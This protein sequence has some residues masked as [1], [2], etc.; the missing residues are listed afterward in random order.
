[1]ISAGKNYPIVC[2][3]FLAAAFSLLKIISLGAALGQIVPPKRYIE[4]L[5]CSTSEC[6]LI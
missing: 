5:T 4:V 2:L 1:M 3:L 6:N